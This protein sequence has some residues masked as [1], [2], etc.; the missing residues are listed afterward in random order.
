[1][2]DVVA[3]IL[4]LLLL[5]VAA[6][7]AATLHSY[8]RS[9]ERLRRD[10]RARGQTIVAEIPKE[11]GLKCFTFDDGCFYY[12]G[13]AIAKGQVRAARVLVN[14]A[15]IAASVS[16]RFPS[17]RVALPLTFEDQPDGIARD[18]WDVAIEAAEGMIL[19]ECGA[20][21]ERV[22]QELA[23]KVFEVVKSEIE[24]RDG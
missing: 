8:R 12:G 13:Q 4:A 24:S 9:R 19:V 2:R 22:S 21:R 14:G 18:R 10:L 17:A 3:A 5:F 7:L 6:S 20:I 1:M 23:Q 11:E 15:P 16:R